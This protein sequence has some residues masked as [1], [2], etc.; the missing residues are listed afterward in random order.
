MITNPNNYNDKLDIKG[1]DN[2]LLNDMLRKNAYNK[3]S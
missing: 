3:I 1:L 2:S